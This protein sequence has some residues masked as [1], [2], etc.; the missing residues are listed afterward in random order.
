MD[1]AAVHHD[2]ERAVIG[3]LDILEHSRQAVDLLCAP[4]I[5]VMPVDGWEIANKPDCII[6]GCDTDD[7]A[8]RPAILLSLLVPGVSIEHPEPMLPCP[9]PYPAAPVSLNC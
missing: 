6:G 5:C 4:A 8:G 9:Y 7:G 2:P 3:D 1:E